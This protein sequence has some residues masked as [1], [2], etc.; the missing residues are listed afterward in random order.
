LGG[1]P[2]GAASAGLAAINAGAA[3][4]AAGGAESIAA[5]VD[6]ARTALADGSAREALERFVEASWRYAPAEAPT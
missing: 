6:A 1:E 5:G 3:I 2:A 4:Y